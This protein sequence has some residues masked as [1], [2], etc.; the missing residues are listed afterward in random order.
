MLEDKSLVAVEDPR[1]DDRGLTIGY[2]REGH[3]NSP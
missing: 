1:L 2:C 3:V